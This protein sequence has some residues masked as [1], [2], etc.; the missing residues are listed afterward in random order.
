MAG[1]EIVRLPLDRARRG[2]HRGSDRRRDELRR[3]ADARLLRQLARPQADR[4]RRPRQG[5]AAGR[6]LHRGGVARRGAIARRDGRRHRRRR[7]P[8][9]RQRAQFRRPLR[10]PVRDPAEARAADAGAARRRDGRRRR[11]AQ[12]RADAVDPR[13]AHPPREGDEQHLH[14]FRPVR[15]GLLDPPDA[16]RRSRPAA[17]SPRST[18]PPRSTSPS[19]SA[20]SRA[21]AC[22]TTRFFNEFTIRTPREAAGADRRAGAR[23]ESS[24]ACRFRGSRRAPGST[25]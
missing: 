12:L 20:R 16:A 24:A 5:R 21:S 7:G 22:S 4:R 10:R 18:T 11:A 3:R 13:A 8:V 19:G 1:D 25:T 14:Q 9:D 17:A 2:G 23:A 6:R 15:A